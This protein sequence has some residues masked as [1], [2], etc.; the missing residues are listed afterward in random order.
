MAAITAVF[1][2]T[3]A[4]EILGEDEDLP[5]QLSDTM[6]PEDGVLWIYDINEQQTLAFTRQ[7]IDN[8]RELISD[9]VPS[10]D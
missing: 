10:T 5:W 6:E 9:R 8:L 1:T 7:G 4:T 2:L 3:R